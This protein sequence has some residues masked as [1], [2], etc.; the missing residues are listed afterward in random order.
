MVVFSFLVMD[1]LHLC[2][3]GSGAA[4]ES[5]LASPLRGEE[6]CATL[7]LLQGFRRVLLVI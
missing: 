3:A 1:H 2:G 6:G 5:A 7:G 4:A